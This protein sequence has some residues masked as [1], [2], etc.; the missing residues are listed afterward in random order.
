MFFSHDTISDAAE[1][2]HMHPVDLMS[3]VMNPKQVLA[4]HLCQ[5][6]PYFGLLDIAHTLVTLT[7]TRG[8][9]GEIAK[10]FLCFDS[11]ENE[12]MDRVSLD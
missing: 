11:Y 6:M 1:A 5:A 12:G 7:F 9:N 3:D 4:A 10:I 2:V 8:C